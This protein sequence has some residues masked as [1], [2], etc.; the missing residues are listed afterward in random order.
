[1]NELLC[2]KSGIC[3]ATFK[4]Y[5]TI[6]KLSKIEICVAT[7]KIYCGTAELISLVFYMKSKMLTE[8]LHF[9]FLS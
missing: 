5:C 4:I 9:I 1:M 2:L 6:A 8:L 3:T 7:F